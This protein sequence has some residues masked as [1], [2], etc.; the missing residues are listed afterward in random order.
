LLRKHYKEGAFIATQFFTHLFYK[1][2]EKP[3][4]SKKTT[5]IQK[6]CFFNIFALFLAF[7][8]LSQK[9]LNFQRSFE[10]V[11]LFTRYFQNY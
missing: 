2:F 11:R 8:A 1:I 7:S 10:R 9:N 4:N 6:I 5:K 3:K